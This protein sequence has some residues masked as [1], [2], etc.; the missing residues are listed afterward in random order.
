MVQSQNF[1]TCISSL[2]A[3]FEVCCILISALPL[4]R[5]LISPDLTNSRRVSPLV[6]RTNYSTNIIQIKIYDSIISRKYYTR[7]EVRRVSP[8]GSKHEPRLLSL[9]P[10][11]VDLLLSTR[12]RDRPGVNIMQECYSF[13]T[14]VLALGTLDTNII[15]K[16]TGSN[17]AKRMILVRW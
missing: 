7:L 6:A 16:Y 11:A 9:R 1:Y 8:L 10:L 4:S 13:R 2:D 12:T 5:L 17:N 3:H 15:D 14:T